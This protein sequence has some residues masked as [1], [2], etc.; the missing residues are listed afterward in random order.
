MQPTL[1]IIKTD[2]IGETYRKNF[3]VHWDFERLLAQGKDSL[4]S[5]ASNIQVA[6]SGRAVNPQDLKRVLF[7]I[8]Q[9]LLLSQ[10]D[11]RVALKNTRRSRE[12]LRQMGAA[13]S[14]RFNEPSLSVQVA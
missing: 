9:C 11:F 8:D 3:A 4:V 1:F 13:E 2:P 6:E 14:Q 10:E 12:I 7:R 5:L